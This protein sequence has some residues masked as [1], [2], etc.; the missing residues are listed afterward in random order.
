MTEAEEDAP[1][2][3]VM[4]YKAHKVPQEKYEAFGALLERSKG[5]KTHG[6]RAFNYKGAITF[7]DPMF[8]ESLISLGLLER[9][10]YSRVEKLAERFRERV[11]AGETLEQ[12]V[13]EAIAERVRGSTYEERMRRKKGGRRI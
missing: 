5:C 9:I 13:Q 3:T 2:I 8:D 7:I 12:C 6:R 1:D 10:D 4:C 11:A